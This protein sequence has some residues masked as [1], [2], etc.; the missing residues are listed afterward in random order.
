MGNV[1]GLKNRPCPICGAL[2]PHRTLYARA[3]VGGK[4]KWMCLFWA[5]E[6]CHSLNHVSVPAYDLGRASVTLPSPLAVAIVR[7]LE[8]GPLDFNELVAG[9]RRT[10]PPLPGHVFKTAVALTLEFLKGRGIVV[11]KPKDCTEDAL[12]T[13]RQKLFG[14]CPLES[15]RTLASLY[16]QKQG[17]ATSHPRFVSAGVY[18]TS[19]GYHQEHPV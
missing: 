7:T 6:K 8:Q 19:C 18:C 10:Q 15:K 2:T 3:T 16:A 17:G 11:E 9:L 14:V 13:L 5:C 4:R 1:R 12:E